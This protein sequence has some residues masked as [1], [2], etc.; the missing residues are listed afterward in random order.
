M[1]D[2]ELATF[3]EKKPHNDKEELLRMWNL[4]LEAGQIANLLHISVKLVHI[5]LKEFG[6]R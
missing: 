4:G 6:I 1:E 2:N 5:K 3:R